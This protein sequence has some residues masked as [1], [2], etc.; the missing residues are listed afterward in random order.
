[1]I[2]VLVASALLAV[3]LVVL[4]GSLSPLLVGTQVGQRR[5]IEERLARSQIEELMAQPASCDSSEIDGPSIDSETYRIV[6]DVDCSR[7]GLA[8]Y[9]VTVKD[10]GGGGTSL[11]DE[12][13]VP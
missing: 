13:V 6:I 12:R 4:L 10:S 9:K 5:T 11:T 2:E 7:P 3:A 1:L 8:A